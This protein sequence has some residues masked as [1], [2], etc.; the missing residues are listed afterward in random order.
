MTR[1]VTSMVVALVLVSV[2]GA[3]AVT[4]GTGAFLA[5]PG[6]V[7]VAYAAITAPPIEAAFS[8]VL[9]GLVVDVVAGTSL[10]VSS[11]SLLVTLLLARFGVSL[12]PSPRHPTA[13]AFVAAFAAVE[14]LVS[15][16]L[17]A[18]FAQR[19]A[20]IAPGK[21][22]VVSIVDTVIAFLLFSA[23]HELFVLLHLEERTATLKERLQAR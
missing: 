4:F 11:F 2:L 1:I 16:L 5:T 13:Y 6:A 23:L 18:L 14:A 17:L 9:V 21:I 7:V 3:L 19:H 15:M 8:A 10:G 20:P 12:V 22:V